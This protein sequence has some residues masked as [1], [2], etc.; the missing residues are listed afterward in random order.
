MAAVLKLPENI[1]NTSASIINKTL[2]T[3]ESV[4][5]SVGD[6]TKSTAKVAKNVSDTA[7]S[8]TKIP[9]DVLNTVSSATTAI[10]SVADRQAQLTKIKTETTVQ[11]E[12]GAQEETTQQQTAQIK[13]EAEK[14]R[15]VAE[16]DAIKKIEEAKQVIFNEKNKTDEFIKKK[17]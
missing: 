12:K 6:I 15:M 5:S 8:A 3:S 13:T 1:L 10:S 14:K 4:V 11:S 7:E 16:R 17:N 2:D 9:A